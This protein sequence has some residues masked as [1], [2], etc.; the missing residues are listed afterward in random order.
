[1]HCNKGLS[2]YENGSLFTIKADILNQVQRY[3]EAVQAAEISIS[4]ADGEQDGAE[5]NVISITGK[6]RISGINLA[7]ISKLLYILCILFGINYLCRIM[8][9]M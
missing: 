8:F 4:R 5:K 9:V 2:L 7:F 6:T 1:M 3:S